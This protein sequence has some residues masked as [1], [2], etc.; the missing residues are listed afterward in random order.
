MAGRPLRH[1]VARGRR[2]GRAADGWHDLLH[3][4]LLDA[5]AVT[6]RRGVV[7]FLVVSGLKH[8]WA[9]A[10]RSLVDGATS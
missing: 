2:S 8:G 6:L 10:W 5:T 3:G 4:T 9:F 7:D 1:D